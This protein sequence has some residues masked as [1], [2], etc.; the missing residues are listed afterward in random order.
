MSRCGD[1][2][3]PRLPFTTNVTVSASDTV[4][5]LLVEKRNATVSPPSSAYRV[6]WNRL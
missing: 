4:A 2:T 6:I 1:I 5:P 3:L